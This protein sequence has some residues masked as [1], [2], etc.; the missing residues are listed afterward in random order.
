MG[1]RQRDA[2]K[3]RMAQIFNHLDYVEGGLAEFYELFNEHHPGL[4]E[5]LEVAAQSIIL[6]DNIIE[7]FCEQAWAADRERILKY[8]K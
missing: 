2:L 8:R 4:A 7:K 1:K 6:A 5:S 3:R